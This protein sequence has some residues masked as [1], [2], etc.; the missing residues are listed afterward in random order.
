MEDVPR[1]Y[2]E[3]NQSLPDYDKGDFIRFLHW[4]ADEKAMEA[5]ELIYV[6]EKPHKFA[7]EYAEFLKAIEDEDN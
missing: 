1:A 3:P 4:L 2:E 6:I 5:V 7:D